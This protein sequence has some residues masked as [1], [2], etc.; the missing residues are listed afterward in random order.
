MANAL[1]LGDEDPTAVGQRRKEILV[2]SVLSEVVVVELDPPAVDVAERRRNPVAQ[3]PVKET[4]RVGY[5]ASA[6]LGFRSVTS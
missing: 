4:D 2:E 6:S 3:V 5:A 1:V